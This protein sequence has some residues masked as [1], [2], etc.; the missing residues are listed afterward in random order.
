MSKALAIGM[1]VASMDEYFWPGFNGLWSTPSVISLGESQILSA[2]Y[3]IGAL[4]LWCMPQ[5]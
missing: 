5:R 3:L 1:L 4:V 2:V